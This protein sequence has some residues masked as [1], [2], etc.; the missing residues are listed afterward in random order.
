MKPGTRALGIAESFQSQTSTVCG[1]VS[2]TAGDID[3]FAFAHCTVGGLDA[4][5]TIADL[6]QSLDR[7]DIQYCLISGIAPAWFNI[8][9]L[10]QL[11][12]TLSTPVIVLTFE[13]GDTLVPAIR[14][15]FKSAAA[16]E[17]IERYRAL[18][19]PTEVPLDQSTVYAR[20]LDVDST[21]IPAI[22]RQF[23]RGGAR[24]EPLRVARLAARAADKWCR[25]DRSR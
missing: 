10:H 5:D 11:S 3:G 2:T 6:W 14:N 13:S 9:D 16:A 4:T 20:S 18:P 15:A 8:L 22:I 12:Q 23:T 7:E 25:S 17:R 1:A 21:A 19:E 24:P